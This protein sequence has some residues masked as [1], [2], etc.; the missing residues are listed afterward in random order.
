MPFPALLALAIFFFDLAAS[1]MIINYWIDIRMLEPRGVIGIISVI[2]SFS[3]VWGIIN[4][5]TGLIMAPIIIRMDDYFRVKK[6]IKEAREEHR[7]RQVSL[8]EAPIIEKEV[9]PQKSADLVAQN[10]DHQ[11][12]FLSPETHLKIAKNLRKLAQRFPEDAEHLIYMAQNRENIAQTQETLVAREHFVAKVAG[13]ENPLE[14]VDPMDPDLVSPQHALI[15]ALKSELELR[16]MQTDALDKMARDQNTLEILEHIVSYYDQNEE[17]KVEPQHLTGMKDENRARSKPVLPP[18][19]YRKIAANLRKMALKYPEDA[20]TYNGLAK[21]NE[22]LANYYD[23]DGK[24][25]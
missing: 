18:T 21:A 23:P 13:I 8:D 17:E 2:I 15:A 9:E 25:K 20:S 1:A 10:I 19:A 3:I 12:P 6:I 24:T 11:K 4:F 5:I 7:T 16:G 22:A 14:F